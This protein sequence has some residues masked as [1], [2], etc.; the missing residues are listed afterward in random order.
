M[1]VKATESAMNRDENANQGIAAKLMQHRRALYSYLFACVRDSHLAEDLIQEVAQIALESIG[2]LR[3]PDRF[4][5]WLFGI[6]RRRVLL[7]A[8][9]AG[10]ERTLPADVVELMA[11]DVE[12]IG[13]QYYLDRKEA[14]RE[15]LEELPDHSRQ[16]IMQRYDGST[17][18]IGELAKRLGR[19][20]QATYGL[21]KRI[22]LKL[23]D[24]V[25]QKLGEV[26]P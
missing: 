19:T 14:L 4:S 9:Q 1:S 16:A 13:N 25:Q 20:V 6:A 2:D 22:R 3:D 10:R 11:A 17:S 26:P 7:H 21:L 24:C 23:A 5:N 15:C 12:R 18:D 8:R